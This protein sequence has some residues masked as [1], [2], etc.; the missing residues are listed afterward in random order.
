M[1]RFELKLWICST[2]L[3]FLSVL[4]L[5]TLARCYDNFD[6][7]H[8]ITYL[9]QLNKKATRPPAAKFVFAPWTVWP[10]LKQTADHI[11]GAG[12]E[13]LAD[14]FADKG[15]VFARYELGQRGADQSGVPMAYCDQLPKP[16]LLAASTATL[17]STPLVNPLIV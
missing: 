16:T 6:I 14:I 17:Y 7:D 10:V 13:G 3:T 2:I 11:R 4:L 9:R 1:N 8:K 15:E 12:Q 5:P